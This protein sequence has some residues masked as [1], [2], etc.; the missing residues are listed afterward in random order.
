MG[1]FL[2]RRTSFSRIY[3]G[4]T[5]VPCSVRDYDLGI[6]RSVSGGIAK[7]YLFDLRG[8]LYD[9]SAWSKSPVF[10]IDN[11]FTHYV[12]DDAI[13]SSNCQFHWFLLLFLLQ[14]RWDSF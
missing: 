14:D 10:S 4:T 9:G 7:K 1:V 12:C 8:M 13:H 6:D 3:K 2:L 5:V 11:L